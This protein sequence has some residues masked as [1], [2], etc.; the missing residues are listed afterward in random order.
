[1]FIL[2][3]GFTVYF[4]RASLRSLRRVDATDRR[5]RIA[6]REI[7]EATVGGGLDTSN[8]TDGTA[9]SSK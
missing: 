4:S 8:G 1:M 3:A 2:S 5:P 9:A 6:A 7:R